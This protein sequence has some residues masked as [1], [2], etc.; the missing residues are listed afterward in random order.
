M[1]RSSDEPMRRRLRARSYQWEKD[2]RDQ[3][4]ISGEERDSIERLI[5]RKMKGVEQASPN[6]TYS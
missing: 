4:D 2:I 1:W 5:K 6:I 3:I